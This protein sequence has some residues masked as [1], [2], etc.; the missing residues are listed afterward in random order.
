MGILVL[1][2]SPWAGAAELSPPVLAW[3]GAQTNLQTWSADF[4][5]TRTLKSLAQPLTATGRVW[6]ATP[7]RFR[8][9]LGN[10]A[11]TIAV[12]AER[13]LLVIYPR[14]QRVERFPLGGRGTGQ[15]R[16]ALSL[17]EAGFPRTRKELEAQYD[18]LAQSTANGACEVKLQPKSAAARR[19][20]PLVGITFD[21]RDF[22]LRATELQFADGSTMRNDF[23]NGRVNP[24]LDEGIF[25][26][27]IPP[28]YKVTEPFS[29]R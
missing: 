17:L 14:L 11:Q 27:P 16:E 8:W 10:P 25:A 1:A 20:M 7:Y 26:P 9:E 2:L 24:K 21:T 15:W 23:K 28:E 18:I 5:Q 22:S 29:N 4:I 3:L 6:F 13:D 19:M 12:R